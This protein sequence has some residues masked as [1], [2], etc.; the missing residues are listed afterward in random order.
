MR[1]PRQ[2]LFISF[3]MAT[4]GCRQAPESQSDVYDVQR[5]QMVRWDLQANGITSPSVLAAMQVV[6]RHLFLPEQQRDA[7]YLNQE[8]PIGHF[9]T[10]TSPYVIAKTIELL[11]LKD[12]DK[13]LEVGTG[14]G[15][16]TAV[17]AELAKEVY[18]IEIVPEVFKQADETL[19]KLNYRNIHGRWRDANKGW[20]EAQPFDAIVISA[21]VKDIPQ[22]LWDQLAMGGRLIT[23][24]DG[25]LPQKLALYRKTPEGPKRDIIMTVNLARMEGQA[26]S[27][28]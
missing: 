25:P 3:L 6:P 14:S 27:Q 10:T 1:I 8:L 22:P 15:Y 18:T 2:W 20:P 16:Q 28:H 9:I 4:G 23:A 5:R 19:K 7:A 21:S 11:D 13:V 12:S 24:L 17:L 26:V